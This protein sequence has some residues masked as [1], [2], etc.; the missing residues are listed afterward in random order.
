MYLG[1][2]QRMEFSW[3]IQRYQEF[4]TSGA[5]TILHCQ[6]HQDKHESYM[7]SFYILLLFY[8]IFCRVASRY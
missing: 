8:F 6:H 4:K 5:L 7:F 2:P 1:F 3:K